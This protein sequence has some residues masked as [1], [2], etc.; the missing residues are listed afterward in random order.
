MISSLFE[1]T[2]DLLGSFFLKVISWPI[3]WE[4][5]DFIPLI[6]ARWCF[7]M[8]FSFTKSD[9]D[10]HSPAEIAETINP[11]LEKPWKVLRKSWKAIVVRKPL[12]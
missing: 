4:Y 9:D 6:A 2:V 7:E 1:S 11:K 5:H 3:T 10:P 8:C 12:F